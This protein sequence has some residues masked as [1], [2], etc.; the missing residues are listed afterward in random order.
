MS[1]GNSLQSG[2][3]RNAG[4]TG[5]TAIPKGLW[6]PAQGCEERAT[7]GGRLLLFSTPMGLC[8]RTTSETQPLRGC[9][10]LPRFPGVARFLATPGFE[11]E[12][13]WDSLLEFPKRIRLG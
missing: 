11:P 4:S 3:E 6:P 13:L 8:P 10:A 5:L 9:L 1:F 12:Y 7:L 2:V